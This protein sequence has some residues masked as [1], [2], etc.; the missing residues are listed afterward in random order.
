[1]K[2][3]MTSEITPARINIFSSVHFADSQFPFPSSSLC[4]GGRT[5]LSGSDFLSFVWSLWFNFVVIVGVIVNDVDVRVFGV[6]FWSS[7]RGVVDFVVVVFNGVVVVVFNRVVVVVFNGVV[8]VVF[9]GVVAA[10][11]VDSI[12]VFG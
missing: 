9:N 6:G 4:F 1:M 5:L 2:T 10:F 11:V 12:V 8:V 7:W 3:R